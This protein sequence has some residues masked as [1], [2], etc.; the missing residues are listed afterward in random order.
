MASSDCVLTA[1]ELE[2]L[3][4]QT[5][6]RSKLPSIKD[7]SA[8]APNPHLKT[9]SRGEKL[10][11]LLDNIDSDLE[12]PSDQNLGYVNPAAPE[13][14]YTPSEV[15]IKDTVQREPEGYSRDVRSAFSGLPK[16]KPQWR[17]YYM[18]MLIVGEC[19][20]GK[21]TFIKNLFASY[22]QDP[23]MKVNDV[24]GSTSK[25][26][27]VQHPDKLLTEIVVK[28]ERNMIAYHYRVQDTPGYD[29]MEVNLDPVI[30]HIQAQNL[31]ALEHEQNAKR[32]AAMSK[33]QD[34]RI[35]VCVYF[36]APHR[37]KQIDVEFM[38]RLSVEVPVLPVLAKADCMT[39]GELAS[40]RQYVRNTLHH[41]S[42]EVGRPIVHE[43]S[44][45]ALSEAGATHLVP[46]FSVVASNTMDL[47]VGRFWPVREYPWGSCEVLSSR[48][49][50]LAALKKLLFEVSYMEL[51]DATE[52]RYYHYRETQLLNLDDS[53][54][55]INRGT[56][57]RHLRNI[58]KPPSK[59]TKNGLLSFAGNV[60]KFAI[61][62]AV[63]YLAVTA[64]Q[65][66]RGK[67]R[68]K[69]DLHAVADRSVEF[70]EVVQDKSHQ[71][72]DK[73]KEA[74]HVVSER[75]KQAKDWTEDTAI[76]AKDTVE[77]TFS[78][79]SKQGHRKAEESRREAEA[80]QERQR[81]INQA[82][83]ERQRNKKGKKFGLF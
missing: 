33:W 1:E 10:R 35:D 4:T 63:V 13:P 75:A 45:D 15:R 48:H 77:D 76:S 27:F 30:D 46:P 60:A 14:S 73:S 17:D 34:P 54:S 24:P 19:G 20:Q 39:A 55:P 6:T 12:A 70:R 41:A 9:P 8:G 57:T 64:L 5:E 51:K 42:K 82:E 58:T 26:T 31:K 59:P 78:H 3:T 81:A 25:E 56:L 68:L 44:R 50:D 18:K 67:D 29:N 49:S 23:N 32:E 74:G 43:F 16:V 61:Q 79:G 80:E 11:D 2:K 65:G 36:I 71:A 40:F 7:E 66:Q 47:S 38:K 69:E 21:T 28:D 83:R 52:S 62:G 72:L 22:T 37:L 53:T